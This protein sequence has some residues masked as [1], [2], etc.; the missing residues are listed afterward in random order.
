MEKVY[1]KESRLDLSGTG[2]FF[3]RFVSRSF[4][5]VLSVLTFLLLFSDIHRLKWTG[6]LFGLFLIDEAIH[7]GEGERDL[8]ELDREN[9]NVASALTAPAYNAISYAF[10]KSSLTGEAFNLLLLR[11][12]IDGKEAQEAL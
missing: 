8:V 5:I 6:I 11:A 7:F 1:F 10:R 2:E 4:Y 12:L 3:V 9:A